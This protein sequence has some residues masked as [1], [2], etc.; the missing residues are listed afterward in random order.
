MDGRLADGSA[1]IVKH[2]DANPD[3]DRARFGLG[4]TQ[5][6]QAYEHVGQSLYRY[7]LR[8]ERSFV[9]PHPEIRELWPQNPKPEKIDY[10][11]ARKIVQTFVDD[12]NRAEATLAEV[13]DERVKLPLHV[14]RIKIDFFGL[15]RPVNAGFLFQLFGQGDFIIAFDRGDV[16]WLRGYCHFLA[17]FGE[18]LLAVDSQPLF[19]CTAHLLFEDVE[20]PHTFLIEDREPFVENFWRN[21]RVLSDIIATIHLLLRFPVKEPDRLKVA[22]GH[23]LSMCQMSREMWTHFS[24]ETDDDNE[25]IPNSKQRGVLGVP[26]TAD[27]IKT[28][29]ATVAEAELVLEGKRLVPF[30]RGTQADRGINLKRVFYEPT[31]IDILLWVQGTAATPYLEKGPLT[32]FIEPEMIGRIDR[33]FG[34]MNF[35]RFVFWFN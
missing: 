12:M 33:Q 2:L 30:W 7:G 9:E 23:L 17:A 6:L 26:V 13:K 14:A 18:V 19:E 27:M 8:T 15:E 32:K 35:I 3:D 22:H 34:G 25:W 31:D 24:A 20:T 16:A 11:A 5:F 10:A 28:W 29:L 1:A 4:V 21:P